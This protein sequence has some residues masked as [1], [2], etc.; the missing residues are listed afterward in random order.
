MR[1]Q[2]L[3]KIHV[4]LYAAFLISIGLFYSGWT[5]LS[6]I[7]D[8][9]AFNPI[10]NNVQHMIPGDHHEQFYRYSL[11]YENITRWRMPYYTGYQFASTEFT[12][13]LIFFPFS[14]IV[15]LMTFVFG[16]ILSYNLMLL[17][18][19]VFVG[20][21]GYYMVKEMTKSI[22]GGMV[23]GIFLATV[24]FRTTFLYGEMVFGV[25]AVM[26]PL[27][28]YFIERARKEKLPQQFFV[29]G[30]IMFF[31]ITANFQ[32]FYWAI[33]L[34]IPY[35]LYA[36]TS[37]YHSFETDYNW[38]ARIRPALW[39]IPGAVLCIA[40]GIYIYVTVN[41][42][43]VLSSG[44]DVRELFFYAPEPYRLFRLGGHEKNVY[45]GVTALF[46][47]PWAL[48]TT[49]LYHSGKE[50]ALRI[51][52]FL[53][54]FIIG[55]LCIFG[56]TI[57]T[58]I[59]I[60]VYQWLFEHLPGVNGTRTTGRIM[61]VVMVLYTVLLG[62]FISSLVGYLRKRFSD[63]MVALVVGIISLLIVYDFY[64]TK[65]G[66][67]T[68]EP[69]SQVYRSIEGKQI[70]VITLPVHEGGHHFNSTFLPYALKYDLR[71]FSGHSSIYPK[72]F[73]SQLVSLLTLN[74]GIIDRDQWRW[75]IDQGYKYII[76]HATKFE[77]NIGIGVLAFLSASPYLNFVL[78]DRGVHLYK[79]HNDA[80]IGATADN[81]EPDFN[82]LI[83]LIE[84]SSLGLDD[85]RK[86]AI[87]QFYGWYTREVYVGHRPFRWMRG[88]HSAFLVDT[89][90]MKQRTVYFD[91]LCAGNTTLDIKAYGSSATVN[92]ERTN[93]SW[94]RATITLH[95]INAKQSIISLKTPVVFEAP[96]DTRKFGCQIADIGVKN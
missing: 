35:F 64:Y 14:A 4:F 94:M 59:N 10:A 5:Y 82:Y 41:C 39:I 69:E 23:A 58:A 87:Q 86:N 15:G 70:K 44:K 62:F 72:K 55:M 21:A 43:S 40:Y 33:L 22:A 60:P 54:M 80:D 12:E 29:V 31:T 81:K 68:F 11:F 96:P 74:D 6:H 32:L 52:L 63:L 18:S 20:L 93:D 16:S 28:I 45:L 47:L 61:A 48:V 76:V 51:L 37:Y 8:A 57:D 46:V 25:D 66:M 71:L 88:T 30:L 85:R 13:G 9:I 27:L 38:Q 2:K 50:H 1:K 49:L 42:G 84:N 53:F 89:H 90:G 78:S 91:Y 73:D 3:I 67:N 26:I 92:H 75:M 79:I 34:L 17:F 65:P 24:P 95:N 56:I 19:Y 77:P 36:M 7:N 83:S